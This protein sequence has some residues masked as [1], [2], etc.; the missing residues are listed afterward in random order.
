LKIIFIWRQPAPGLGPKPNSAAAHFV[1]ARPV[2]DK[3]EKPSNAAERAI[4]GILVPVNSPQVAEG[5]WLHTIGRTQIA[6]VMGDDGRL[7]AMAHLAKRE[8]SSGIHQAA[9][10]ICTARMIGVAM[11]QTARSKAMVVQR[12]GRRVS[13]RPAR[14]NLSLASKSNLYRLAVFLTATMLESSPRDKS[15]IGPRHGMENAAGR[16]TTHPENRS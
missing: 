13:L 7:L 5:V 1:T 4:L 14:R 16:P 9:S 2:G 10:P 3:C 8:K 6:G 11:R 12:P 15:Q